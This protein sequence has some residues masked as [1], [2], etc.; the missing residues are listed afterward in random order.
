MRDYNMDDRANG[1]LCPNC[2]FWHSAASC[3]P[4]YYEMRNRI[5]DEY[6][7]EIRRLE[8][9]I[10]EL[11]KEKNIIPTDIEFF[12][13]KNFEITPTPTDVYIGEFNS[14]A[15]RVQV[16]LTKYLIIELSRGQIRIK[17]HSNKS[18]IDQ[19]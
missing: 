11:E 3:P 1:N 15:A 14:G 12:G 16:D 5:R 9:R 10:K 6:D 17:F 18:D 13:W 19:V 8:K 7:E 4:Q 2:G